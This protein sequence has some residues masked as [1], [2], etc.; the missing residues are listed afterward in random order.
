MDTRIRQTLMDAYGA[1]VAENAQLL[2]LGGH[3]SLRIYWRITLEAP[4]PRGEKTLMAMVLPEGFDPSKSDEGGDTPAVTELPFV[5]VQRYLRR[6]GLPVGDIDV[7][8]M[9]RGVL[10]LEDLGDATFENV[11]LSDKCNAENLYKE[12]IDLLVD[13]QAKILADD[14]QDCVGYQKSFDQKLL[15]WELDHYREWGL[16]E[17]YGPARLGDKREALAKI[18]E[19]VVQELLNLPQCLV[20]RDYQSRNIMQKSGK[21]V[22]ID[23]QDALVGPFI[24]DLVALLRDSYIVLDPDMVARL[25]AYYGD[26]GRSAGLP[27]CADQAQVENAFHLQTVQRKLKDAGRFIFIDRV[28]NNPSFLP[29]YSPS[30]GYVVNALKHLPQYA[31]LEALLREVEPAWEA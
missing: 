24:Y 23:F 5:N 18:F 7:V 8:D 12:V 21:W 27:W 26:K 2:N 31:H 13:V 3:A 19:D 25:V 9:P 4:G 28:K 30:V 11:Y 6:L 1:E 22:L 29:Y 15:Y 17:H 10:L 14:A 16:D 20:M